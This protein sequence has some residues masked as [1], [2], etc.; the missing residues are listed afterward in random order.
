MSSQ[1]KVAEKRRNRGLW[2]A[3]GFLMIIALLVIAWLLAPGLITWL[4]GSFRGFRASTG[5]MPPLHLQIAFTLII[6]VILALVS[7]IIV[8][9]AAPRRALEFKDK[10]LQKERQDNLDYQ[11]K[12][13]KRQRTLNREM[14]QFV[15]KNQEK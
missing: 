10:D 4:K 14:R 6:F 9:V 3:F 12:A 13:R 2:A 11:R 7:A 8:T 15:E 5:E 1:V